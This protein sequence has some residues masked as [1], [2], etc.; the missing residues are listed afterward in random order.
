VA[1]LSLIQRT[2][3]LHNLRLFWTG[4][5]VFELV[6]IALTAWCLYRRSAYVAVTAMVTA[7]L[8]FSDAWFNIV[9]TIGVA[10][11]AADAMAL[12]ELPMA[13]YSLV[14]ARREV[15]SWPPELLNS[16]QSQKLRVAYS[17]DSKRSR[18]T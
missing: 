1:V 17:P 6:W 8:L 18:V 2:N 4:L 11:R 9:T 12:V 16:V 7:T 3:E 14:I 10:H 5:D 13:I 15:W